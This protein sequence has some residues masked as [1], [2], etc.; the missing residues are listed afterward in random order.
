MRL[1]IRTTAVLAAFTALG[2]LAAPLLI[3]A[4]A[5]SA[6]SRAITISG[7]AFSPA[8]VTIT[9]GDT[10]TWTNEDQA[11]H[12]VTTTSAPV[13]IHGATMSKGQSWSYRFTV[14]GT[15]SYICSIHPDMKATVTVV[16]AAKPTPTPTPTQAMT[17]IVRHAAAPTPIH[18]PGHASASAAAARSTPAPSTSSSAV[19]IAATA[20]PSTPTRPLRPLLFVAGAIAAIA[21][22]ALLLLAA[23]P[24]EVG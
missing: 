9:T 1:S 4:P 11:P 5:A 21:T 2:L 22:L 18:H 3:G 20:T 24:E 6:A 8:A 16:A 17:T 13:A 23:R 12:D 10:L 14:P 19:P 15:Y 7:Y